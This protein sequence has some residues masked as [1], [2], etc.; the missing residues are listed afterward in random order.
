MAH[1]VRGF[2]LPL[3]YSGGFPAI[4]SIYH[5][6]TSVRRF[7][8]WRYPYTDAVPRSLYPLFVAI[9]R[10]VVPCSVA[11]RLYGVLPACR[12]SRSPVALSVAGPFSVARSWWL[13]VWAPPCWPGIPVVAYLSAK[14]ATRVAGKVAKVAGIVAVKVASVCAIVAQFTPKS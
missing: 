8:V 5:F 13:V 4:C 6:N 7:N 1:A 3:V 12:R 9:W 2:P 11:C 10:G 14:V